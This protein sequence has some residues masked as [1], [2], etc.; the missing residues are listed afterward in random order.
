MRRFVFITH[1]NVCIDPAA[2]VPQW[3]LSERGRERMHA[4]LLQPWMRA[5]T[6]VHCSTEQK[7]IDGAAILSQHL[8]LAH[9]AHDDLGEN[10]RS[11]TGFLPSPE[12]ET[13]AGSLR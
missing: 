9:T 13:K 12:F 1:P 5:V 7:A 2:P 11:A 4:S 8:G 6:T 3:P 10:D